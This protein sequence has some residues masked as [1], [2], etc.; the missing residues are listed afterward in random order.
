MPV[1]M[2]MLWRRTLGPRFR[3]RGLVFL[4]LAIDDYDHY[5]NGSP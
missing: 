1:E 2:S 3:Q 5:V 4:G